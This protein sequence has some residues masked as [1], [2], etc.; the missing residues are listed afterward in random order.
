M[1]GTGDI[2]KVQAALAQ[3]PDEGGRVAEESSD[4]CDPS[5]RAWASSSCFMR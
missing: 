1:L 3:G 4:A 2:R 5:Y